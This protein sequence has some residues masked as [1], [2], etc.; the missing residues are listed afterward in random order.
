M[1]FAGERKSCR[2]GGGVGLHAHRLAQMPEQGVAS[3]PWCRSPV[4]PGSAAAGPIP[5]RNHSTGIP[6]TTPSPIRA[7]TQPT[8][9]PSMP[10]KRQTDEAAPISLRFATEKWATWVG[11]RRK[12][13]ISGTSRVGAAIVH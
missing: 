4:Y 6:R 9:G 12:A 1:P 5:R 11:M 13:A 8:H 3:E 7:A 2:D 10:Q